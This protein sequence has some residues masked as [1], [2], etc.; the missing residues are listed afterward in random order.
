MA[1]K[2][3]VILSCLKPK[4]PPE[5]SRRHQNYALARRR[6]RPL[7]APP[8]WDS[9]LSKKPDLIGFGRPAASDQTPDNNDGTTCISSPRR[10]P[11]EKWESLRRV[12]LRGGRALL[13]MELDHRPLG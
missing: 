2:S 8:R 10:S 11:R 12:P 1:S 6:A 13:R 3:S 4:P 5:L 7:P 9:G